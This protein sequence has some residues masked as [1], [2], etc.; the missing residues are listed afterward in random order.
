MA[1]QN[2]NVNPYQMNMFRKQGNNAGNYQGNKQSNNANAPVKKPVVTPYQVNVKPKTSLPSW[3]DA[4]DIYTGARKSDSFLAHAM[5]FGKIYDKYQDPA[6]ALDVIKKQGVTLDDND[7]Q[8]IQ[9]GALNL[10]MTF[11]GIKDKNAID[12][13][14]V[15]MLKFNALGPEAYNAL[16]KLPTKKGKVISGEVFNQ[17]AQLSTQHDIQSKQQYVG[18]VATSDFANKMGNAP[19]SYINNVL[20]PYGESITQAELYKSGAGAAVRKMFGGLEQKINRD[21]NNF[22]Q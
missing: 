20:K 17:M 18:A 4:V 16:R 2:P 12:G 7:V 11:Y 22:F 15:D 8:S 13:A 10:A 5:L 6:K 3:K 19:V 9:N 21:I 14:Y 1:N